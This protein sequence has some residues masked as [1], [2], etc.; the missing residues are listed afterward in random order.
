MQYTKSVIVSG[1]WIKGSDVTSG[2]RAK[3]VSETVKRESQFKNDDG[4]PKI[5]DVAKIQFEGG[6]VTNI[7][8]NRATID[9]LVDAF[10]TESKDW[11]G[12]M[13]TAQT[14]KMIVGGKRVTAL[15]LVPDGAEVAE[16]ENGYMIIRRT[17]STPNKVISP[18]EIPF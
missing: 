5:Q 3:L 4:T 12:K 18:E 16:D 7:A 1:S 9:G 15:Y 13:L 6:E 8:L 14:E 11:V 2:T 17:D 10:G